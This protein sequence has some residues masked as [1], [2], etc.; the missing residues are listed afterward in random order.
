M[1]CYNSFGS[2]KE[3]GIVVAIV[4]F[5][6]TLSMIN[7]LFSSPRQVCNSLLMMSIIWKVILLW[8]CSLNI[9]STTTSAKA[10][11]S[12]HKTN[13][14][15]VTHDLHVRGFVLFSSTIFDL[16]FPKSWHATLLE[17]P[18]FSPPLQLLTSCYPCLWMQSPMLNN[19]FKSTLWN[20]FD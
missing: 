4:V 6:K 10:I 8:S 14:I 12:W 13:F 19:N 9:S 16:T 2:K 20:T 1:R 3:F 17:L 15:L 18:H 7:F 11:S 5:N